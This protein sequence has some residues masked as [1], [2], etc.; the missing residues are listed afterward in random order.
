MDPQVMREGLLKALEEGGEGFTLSDLEEQLSLGNC[1]LWTGNRSCLV[2]SLHTN[3]D[4]GQRHIHVWLGC[5]DMPELIT[6]EP[7][8]SAWARARGCSYASIDGR[9]GWLRIF[10]KSGFKLVDGELRKQYV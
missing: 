2:T 10:K 5:G 7:G 3:T 8:V 6:L 4:T 9:K 1:L